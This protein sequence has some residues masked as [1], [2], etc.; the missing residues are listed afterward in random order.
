MKRREDPCLDSHR[1][2]SERTNGLSEQ[3]F[4]RALEYSGKSSQP[5]LGG[6]MGFL[7]SPGNRSR[8][9]GLLI[10]AAVFT[11]YLPALRGGFI[12]DDNLHVT[13]NQTLRDLG[14]LRGIWFE[15]GKT[16]QYYPLVHSTFWLE[17]HLWQLNPFGYHLVNV[18]LHAL[19]AVLFYRVLMR[20]QLRGAWLP[21]AIFALH[22]VCVE[23]VAWIS[24]RKNVLSAVFY[25]AAA[26]AYLRFAPIREGVRDPAF[27]N[28]KGSEGGGRWRWYVAALLLFVAA[29]LSKTVTCSLP[30]ALLLV[31]WWRRRR[32]TW[33]DGALLLPFF[34]AAAALGLNTVWLEKHCVGAQGAAWSLTVWERCLTAGRAL[35]FYAAKLVWPANLTFNYPRWEIG[36][37]VWWLWCF[38][39][40]ALG[41][42][43]AL[44]LLRH[45]IGR[46]PLVA[47]LFFVG[48][49]FPALGFFDVYPFLYSFVADHFQY[50][51]SLGL[52]T[53][54][55]AGINSAC[56]WFERGKP[57]VKLPICGTL[58][59]VLAVLTWRQCGMYADMETLW[60]TT[61]ARNPD[62][63]L[64]H[65]N[66][67]KELLEKGQADEGIACFRK[68][69]EIHPGDVLA[70]CNLGNA[71]FLK[72][73]VDEA[74]PYFQKA[75]EI[76]P[77]NALVHCN[78]GNALRQKG[79]VNE[80]IVHYEKVLAIVPTNAP[81]ANNVAWILATWPAAS[82]RNGSRAVELAQRAVRLS[83][84]NEPIF[85]GTLAAAYAEAG[86]FDEAVAAGEQARALAL[87]A[88]KAELAE[89][90]AALLELYRARQ[91]YRENSESNTGGF[92]AQIGP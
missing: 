19:A 22:P 44:W 1:E 82:I 51:A 46:G 9:I 27:R 79:R 28:D 84:S 66:L 30:A 57:F 55:G 72:G 77:D 33:R 37:A 8:F 68:T 86:R 59:L 3:D 5:A 88:G 61:I 36:T 34:V 41:V 60:R 54:A 56:G 67:G 23:S 81:L 90:N 47:V 92:D 25:L 26:L 43:A 53:L 45:R 40:A 6:V 87:A 31:G 71:L 17:Y 20:L 21:A 65:N 32:I 11:A 48:T 74:I 18:L 63:W 4:G 24:E 75:L 49:L 91:P 70:R 80:A 7:A 10:L 14:G 58:L 39:V 78:L 2:N 35:F 29:L 50:L 38:P 76:E 62:S 69:L 52:V 15:I 64:A 73:Q 85:I 83:G 89:R 42:I 16:I 13:Q 12:W